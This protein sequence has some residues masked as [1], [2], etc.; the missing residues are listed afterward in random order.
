M[1]SEGA[2]E[3]AGAGSSLAESD[4]IRPITPHTYL[5]AVSVGKASNK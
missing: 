2:N 4:A 5:T 1:P 3:K